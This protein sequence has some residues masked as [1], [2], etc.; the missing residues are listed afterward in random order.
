MW[1]IGPQDLGR[2]RIHVG[3]FFNALKDRGNLRWATRKSLD[4]VAKAYGDS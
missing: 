1:I 2:T 3:G 4:D